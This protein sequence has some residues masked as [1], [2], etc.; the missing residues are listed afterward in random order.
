MSASSVVRISLLKLF[1]I[2]AFG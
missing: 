2:S 1:S